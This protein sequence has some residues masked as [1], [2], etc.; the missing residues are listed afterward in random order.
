MDLRNSD[1]SLS[2]SALSLHRQGRGISH[3]RVRSKRIVSGRT[4][5]YYFLL[6]SMS[7]FDLNSAL[8]MLPKGTGSTVTL[9]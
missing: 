6:I 7:L 9:T 8:G 5:G 1:G 3:D 2:P 4:R